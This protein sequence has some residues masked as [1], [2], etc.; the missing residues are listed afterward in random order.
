MK[1]IKLSTSFGKKGVINNA[2]KAFSLVTKTVSSKKQG[3][4]A[5]KSGIKRKIWSAIGRVL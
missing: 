3:K 2:K 4:K 1:T 5:P